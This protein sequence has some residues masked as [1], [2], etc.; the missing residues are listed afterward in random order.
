M[1]FPLYIFLII[2]FL[3]L[4]VWGIFGLIGIY[5]MIKFGLLNPA[6]FILTFI[7][8]AGSITFLAVS[9]NYISAIDW[10]VNVSILEGISDIDIN[11]SFIK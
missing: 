2:Y 4:F 6:T 5:H 9:Y 10:N 3:F 7:F 8:I 1:S 11:N